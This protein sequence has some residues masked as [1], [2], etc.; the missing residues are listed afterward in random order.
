[1]GTYK[2]SYLD[3]ETM[4]LAAI[5]ELGHPTKE[6]IIEF[7]DFPKFECEPFRKA[8]RYLLDEGVIK[9]NGGRFYGKE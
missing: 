1:M 5:S 6:E 2:T 7:S 8:L 3:W 9:E 4:I